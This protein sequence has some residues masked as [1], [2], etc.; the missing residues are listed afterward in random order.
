M[1]SI[2]IEFEDAISIDEASRKR[3]LATTGWSNQDEDGD[4]FDHREA[5]LLRL[6][7][8]GE[9][10]TPKKRKIQIDGTNWSWGSC[11]MKEKKLH[12]PPTFNL[13]YTACFLTLV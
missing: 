9:E 4:S 7:D 12:G 2:D 3:K 10:A 5:K 1:K 13:Y 8:E 6:F 11:M